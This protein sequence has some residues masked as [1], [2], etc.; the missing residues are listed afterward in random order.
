MELLWRAGE[1]ALAVRIAVQMATS[2][3]PRLSGPDAPRTIDADYRSRPGKYR[4]IRCDN[5][6]LAEAPWRRGS[7]DRRSSAGCQQCHPGRG[8][9]PRPDG[10]VASQSAGP[11]RRCICDLGH[12]WRVARFSPT[13]QPLRRPSPVARLT[14]SF[15]LKRQPNPE[16][17]AATPDA[18]SWN[19][20]AGFIK[21]AC[22]ADD[23]AG[24]ITGLV[25]DLVS[26]SP[27]VV[28]AGPFQTVLTQLI[29][30]RGGPT[31]LG[32]LEGP[33]LP[34]TPGIEALLA[35]VETWPNEA[36]RVHFLTR[37]LQKQATLWALLVPI[38][39]A[40][41]P[42]CCRASSL[43]R[44]SA[45]RKRMSRRRCRLS[46]LSPRKRVRDLDG[47]RKPAS[48]AE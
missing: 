13:G 44:S 38:V 24:E 12:P 19:R 40:W 4:H 36:E 35:L 41:S 43:Q 18:N 22:A 9:P 21:S 34:V 33:E 11:D 17:L 10:V 39:S 16:P 42:E 27:A 29:Y 7:G 6:P 20:A 23:K 3:D 48:T 25:A 37:T 47:D 46:S 32:L 2:D 15:G 5:R 1:A 8:C 45:C 14:Q 28:V 26:T 31:L 30:K